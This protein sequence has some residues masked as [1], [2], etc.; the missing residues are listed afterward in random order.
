MVHLVLNVL[1]LSRFQMFHADLSFMW[2]EQIKYLMFV[3]CRTKLN[4]LYIQI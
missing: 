4:D 3:L 1:V 2:R